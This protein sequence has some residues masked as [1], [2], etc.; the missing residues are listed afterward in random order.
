MSKDE[1]HTMANNDTPGQ[2]GIPDNWAGIATWAIGRFGIGV[3]FLAMLAYG[4]AIVY[5]DGRIDRDQ[6]L[7]AF[8][9]SIATLDQV[10]VTLKEVSRQVEANTRA[11]ELLTRQ[12]LNHLNR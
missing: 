12:N 2:I 3:I 9:E 10:A 6:S 8:N 5:K 4:I 11:V 7:R 1:L